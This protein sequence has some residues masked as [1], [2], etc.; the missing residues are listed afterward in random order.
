LLCATEGQVDQEVVDLAMRNLITNLGHYCDTQ[1][2]DFIA[3]PRESIR[4][5]RFAASGHQ[6]QSAASTR[7]EE[8]YGQ[9]VERALGRLE[10]SGQQEQRRR[11]RRP[12]GRARRLNQ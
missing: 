6:P 1:R 7:D 8:G 12:R 11:R 9:R 4:D 5:F 2:L 10:R 3:P